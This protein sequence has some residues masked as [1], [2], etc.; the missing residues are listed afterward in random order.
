MGK[1]RPVQFADV[2][3]TYLNSSVSIPPWFSQNT[4]LQMH[5]Y[6]PFI[7]TLF[8]YKHLA[9]TYHSHTC[10][11]SWKEKY[12]QSHGN[13]DKPRGRF[14]Q[15]SS[16]FQTSLPCWAQRLGRCLILWSQT[17]LSQYWGKLLLLNLAFISCFFSLLLNSYGSGSHMGKTTMFPADLFF[18]Y[19][20]P[21]PSLPSPSP[22]SLTTTIVSISYYLKA[23]WLCNC[24][25]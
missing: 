13:W 14:S 18:L 21:P 15:C 3:Y 19:V 17:A 16:V 22:L 24:R 9:F 5:T 25:L 6:V 4:P 7:D 12:Q 10:L 23:G 2:S 8:L 20:S 1:L 11:C